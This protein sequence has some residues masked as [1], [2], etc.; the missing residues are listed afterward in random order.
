MT[1]TAPEP[2]QLSFFDETPTGV[3]VGK[4]AV[5][6]RS[7][8]RV[9]RGSVQTGQAKAEK[10]PS[11]GTATSNAAAEKKA[12]SFSAEGDRMKVLGFIVGK[13]R[14]GATDEEVFEALKFPTESHRARR[15]DLMKKGWVQH[16]VLPGTTKPFRRL[17]R[18]RNEAQ[19]WVATLEGI[20]AYEK[21]CASVN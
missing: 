14:A 11:N 2:L 6:V 21:Y 12:R 20:A 3:I 15:H 4:S 18:A 9:V 1:A 17:T 16:G 5:V 13:K 19:V 8:L 10:L 7:H